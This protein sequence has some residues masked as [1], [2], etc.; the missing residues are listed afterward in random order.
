MWEGEA[1]K[2]SGIYQLKGS[3]KTNRITLLTKVMKLITVISCQVTKAVL[4]ILKPFPGMS[5]LSREHG[6]RNSLCSLKRAIYNTW[7]FSQL[8]QILALLQLLLLLL[9]LQRFR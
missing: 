9:Q 5:I 4:S 2:D 3:G 7:R 6:F 1:Q 8:Y